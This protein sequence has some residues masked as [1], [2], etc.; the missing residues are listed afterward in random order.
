MALSYIPQ[1]KHSICKTGWFTIIL[2]F[3]K[4]AYFVQLRLGWLQKFCRCRCTIQW[5]FHWNCTCLWDILRI[6]QKTEHR[7]TCAHSHAH[8]ST[9]T[10]VH[11]CKGKTYYF[12]FPFRACSWCW[13][14]FSIT[15]INRKSF[16][17]ADSSSYTTLIHHQVKKNRISSHNYC[18]FPTVLIW[19]LV[20]QRVDVQ[21]DHLSL[22]TSSACS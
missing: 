6:G 12:C 19:A 17:S 8:V 1:I 3:D 11:T 10:C 21:Y 9:D 13:H 16:S 18:C 7:H 4:I 15:T 20:R 14:L 22:A 5:L 2:G